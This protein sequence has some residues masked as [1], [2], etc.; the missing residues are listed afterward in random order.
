[1]SS[2]ENCSLDQLIARANSLHLL[3]DYQT[4]E[5][6]LFVHIGKRKY[7]FDNHLAH[8]FLLGLIRMHLRGSEQNRA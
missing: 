6:S 7:I 5:H 2:L 8:T 3:S 1:M 4:T